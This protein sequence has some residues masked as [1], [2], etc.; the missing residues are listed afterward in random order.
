MISLV[1]IFISIANV[2]VQSG[3]NTALIQKRDADEVDFSSVFYLTLGVATIIY[4]LIFL[5]RH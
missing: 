4:I 2:F 1:T 5:E 3:F